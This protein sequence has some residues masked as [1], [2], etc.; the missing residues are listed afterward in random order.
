MTKN[1]RT[2]TQIPIDRTAVWVASLT[3]QG[4]RAETAD[5]MV[6]QLLE[7]MHALSMFHADIVCL[8]EVFPLVG[9]AAP[10]PPARQIAETPPGPIT[11]RFCE[12]ARVHQCYVICPL[13]TTENGKIYNAAVVIDRHGEVLGEYR[14]IHLTEGEL[15]DGLTPGPLD[16][17]VFDTDFGRIGVQICFDIEW[18]DGWQRL[19]N[20]GAEIVFWPS[21]FAGGRALNALASRFH[22]AIV[23]STQKDAS[24]IIDIS[25]TD[26]AVS[27]RWDSKGVCMPINLETAFVHSWPY[28]SAFDTIRQKYGRKILIR[29]FHDEEWSIIESRD[30]EIS[31]KDVLLEFNIPTHDEMT[32]AAE[33]KQAAARN[34]QE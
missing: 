33:A 24:K 9:L 21:A 11:G 3:Q 34:S 28:F 14:K 18:V 4:M 19:A 25:G 23:S 32:R 20:Q 16:A 8:P 31:V 15:E 10:S 12:F 1:A 5:A 30:R 7:R 27:G 2:K 17:P 13:Y 29:S 6:D 22:Y 26:L